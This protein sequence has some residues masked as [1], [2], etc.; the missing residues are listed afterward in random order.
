M[1]FQHHYEICLLWLL[2]CEK[3]HSSYTYLFC[4][5]YRKVVSSRLSQLVAHPRIIRLFMKEN[6]NA[7]EL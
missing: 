3:E 2:L 5:T 6:F 4:S 7:Y 1:S